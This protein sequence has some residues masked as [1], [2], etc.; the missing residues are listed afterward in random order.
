MTETNSKRGWLLWALG[1]SLAF[2]L[3]FL[4]AF[5]FAEYR[6]RCGGCK[7][8]ASSKSTLNLNPEQT[9][10]I[11]EG[12]VKLEADLA[13]LREKMS[14]H[15]RRL[16]EILASPDPDRAA[17]REETAAMAELQRQVQEMIL[18]HHLVERASLPPEQRGCLSG[19]MREGLCG[20]GACG[21]G[22][23]SPACG[24]A[25]HSTDCGPHGPEKPQ[26]KTPSEGETR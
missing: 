6:S 1:L 20:S 24:K 23:G 17:I 18:E 16:S 2:N 22:P 13:P 9:K 3:A 12:R 21:K 8:E 10:A 5:A 15:C 26:T 14:I 7:P 11:R 25:V 19:L 4:A